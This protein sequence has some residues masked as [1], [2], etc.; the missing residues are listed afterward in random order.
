MVLSFS[1]ACL[2]YR[3]IDCDYRYLHVTNGAGA[4]SHYIWRQKFKIIT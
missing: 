1:S 3:Y 4:G 2:K